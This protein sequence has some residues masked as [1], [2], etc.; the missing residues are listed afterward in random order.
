MSRKQWDNPELKALQKI[1]YQK[2]KES[3]FDDIEDTNS[4]REYLKTWHSNYF[5]H[6]YTPDTFADNQAYYRKAS[7]FYFEHKF[8]NK[9][10][11]QIWRDHADGLSFRE[12]AIRLK[13]KGVRANKD[14]VNKVVSKLVAIMQE[15]CLEAD[16]VTSD[17]EG[18][19]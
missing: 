1:W 13:D 12:I 4:P 19:I 15:F 10:E 2:L 18:I 5:H 3:G 11:K 14:S 8:K 6:R 7:I 17:D 16:E 9:T